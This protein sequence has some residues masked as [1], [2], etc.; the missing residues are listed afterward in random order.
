MI[1]S[2]YIRLHSIISASLFLQ[3]FRDKLST[4]FCIWISFRSQIVS[5]RSH[6]EVDSLYG[7]LFSSV[8]LSLRNSIYKMFI[9]E[10]YAVEL[11]THISLEFRKFITYGPYGLL[12]RPAEPRK[13][14][15][16]SCIIPGSYIL[17]DTK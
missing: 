6:H 8:I 9:F 1:S 7:S 13:E 17:N 10:C 3:S 15:C 5:R 4:T 2:S 11:V 16:N 12:P 14:Y